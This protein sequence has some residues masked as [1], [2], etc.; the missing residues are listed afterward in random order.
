MSIETKLKFGWLPLW[1]VDETPEYAIRALPEY[2]EAV[3]EVRSWPQCD[4]EWCWPP[5]LPEMPSRAAEIFFLPETHVLTV[6]AGTPAESESK[7][8][9]LITF[10]GFLFGIVLAPE[11]WG[12]SRRVCIKVNRWP[13]CLIA[14]SARRR[15]MSVAA[16]FWEQL[17]EHHRDLILGIVR[18]HA[19]SVA[20]SEEHEVFLHQYI[21]LDACWKL[22]NAIPH[23]PTK[24]VPHA[25]RI[26]QLASCYGLHIPLNWSG[27]S[28]RSALVEIRNELF[29]EARWAGRPVGFSCQTHP[30]GAVHLELY[31]FTYRLIL[32]LIG[33]ASPYIQS[34]PN[35]QTKT[36]T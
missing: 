34:K 20:F 15:V 21:L 28:R 3:E 25:E 36:L 24:N 14:D 4:E 31:W 13:D 22:H 18:W 6:T 16:L 30:L 26:D 19:L 8:E 5:L 11:G 35:G 1:F 7:A 27:E 33:D 29:H 23:A 9:F 17:P 10:L 32:A 12:Q 2:R